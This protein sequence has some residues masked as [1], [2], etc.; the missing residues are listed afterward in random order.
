MDNP[1]R[2]LR[3]EGIQSLREGNLDQAIDLLAR[4]V[5]ADSQD[6]EAQAFLGVAYS[7]K[8]LHAQAK[9]ALQSAVDLQPRNA[10]FRFNLGV[11]LEQAGDR[12]SA[13]A[14]YREALQINPEHSQARARLQALSA[15]AATA[16]AGALQQPAAGAAPPGDSP[17]LR[18]QQNPLSA[19]QVGPPGTVQCPQC[20]QWSKPGLSCE[21]CSAPLKSRPAPATAP[22]LQGGSGPSAA[23]AVGPASGVSVAPDMSAGEAF[24]RRFAAVFIDWIILAVLNQVLLRMMAGNAVGSPMGLAAPGAFG[25]LMLTSF[26]TGVLITC[27]YSAGM[28]AMRG[29]TLGKMALGVR[30]VGPDGGNPSFWRAALREVIGKWISSLILGLGYFWMLW[31]EEQQTWHDKIASTFVERS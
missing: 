29:Q 6:A 5:M 21:W 24:G 13:A 1:T 14:A 12:Q 27:A 10:G 22:W 28:L 17:W 30:V 2:S 31:D 8:G 7:Q 23:E 25:R 26:G 11:A 9:R 18:G 16:P 19:A 15:A 3:E 4:A 20:K